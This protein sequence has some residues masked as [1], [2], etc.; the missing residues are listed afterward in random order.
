[1]DSALVQLRQ[2]LATYQTQ[3]SQQSSGFTGVSNWLN[4]KLTGSSSQDAA[5]N[6]GVQW[7]NQ[8]DKLGSTDYQAVLSGDQSLEGWFGTAQALHDALVSTG[9]DISNWSFGGIVSQTASATATQV[10]KDVAIGSAITLPLVVLG[11]AL[12][13]FLVFGGRK[14]S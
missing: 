8:I 6:A 13:F 5:V 11:V 9:A 1:M 10:V 7:S 2:A 12:Y 3:L 4:A 14:G